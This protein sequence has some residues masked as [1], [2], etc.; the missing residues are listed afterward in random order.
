MQKRATEA[1]SCGRLA[2]GLDEGMCTCALDRDVR[3]RAQGSARNRAISEGSG[4]GGEVAGL[5]ICDQDG[6]ALSD[7]GLGRP[8]G[9]RE[10]VA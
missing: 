1:E 5:R 4:G 10:G 9:L 7:V 8:N 2:R 6:A 3:G